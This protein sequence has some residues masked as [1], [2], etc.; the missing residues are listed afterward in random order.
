M[1]FADSA[2][3]IHS[4]GSV[5]VSDR[6]VFAVRDATIEL[7]HLYGYKNGDWTYSR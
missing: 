2:G 1:H 5:S 4:D 7:N 3:G 6:F